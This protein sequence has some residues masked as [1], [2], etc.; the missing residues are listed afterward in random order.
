MNCNEFNT[1]LG[2]WYDGELDG[3]TAREV[4]QHLALC[5]RCAAEIQQWRRIDQMLTV[6]LDAGDLLNST[7]E[8]LNRE[9]LGGSMW[10][11]KIAA[12]AVIATGLGAISGSLIWNEPA[13]TTTVTAGG[14]SMLERSFG[15]GALAGIDDLAGDADTIGQRRR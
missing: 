4:G 9:R 3:K 10:W 13:Q 15:P 5:P 6:E 7:L 11:L 12:A 8:A 1:R 14:L 2:R